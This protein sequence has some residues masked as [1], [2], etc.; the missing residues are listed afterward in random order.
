MTRERQDILEDF[1]VGDHKNIRDTVYDK[2][3]ALE[4]LT[5]GEATF[6]LIDEETGETQ[7]TKSSSLVTEIEILDQVANEGELVVYLVPS[8]TLREHPDA[9]LYGTFRYQIKFVNASGYA[10]T[11]TTG[12]ISIFRSPGSPRARHT[13]TFA[14]LAGQ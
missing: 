4:N 6:F 5:G 13:V 9:D 10:S 11:V 1:Y 8:D 7:I 2:D 14:Y 12:R 3:G